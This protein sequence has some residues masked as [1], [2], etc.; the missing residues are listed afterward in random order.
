MEEFKPN[1]MDAMQLENK[2]MIRF[3]GLTVLFTLPAYILIALTGMNIIL[4]PEMVFSFVPFSVLAPL[5]AASYL[6]YKNGGRKAVKFAELKDK[7]SAL[8]NTKSLPFGY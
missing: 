4:S 2:S 3:F 1:T 7:L 8:T 6:T 5:G